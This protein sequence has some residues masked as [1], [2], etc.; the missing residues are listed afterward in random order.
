MRG[1]S[2]SADQSIDVSDVDM[3]RDGGTILFRLSGCEDDGAYRLETPFAGEPRILSR[4][5]TKLQSGEIVER[6]VV[7]HLEQWL[8]PQLSPGVVHAPAEL[9]RIPVWKNLPEHLVAIA[10]VQRIRAV[11]DYLAACSADG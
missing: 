2:R 7:H 4:N 3:L 6:R 5:G 8:E 10:P 1:M 11:V 9:D